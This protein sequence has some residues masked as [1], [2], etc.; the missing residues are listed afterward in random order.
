MDA[1]PN[2]HGFRW[3]FLPVRKTVSGGGVQKGRAPVDVPREGFTVDH[4]HSVLRHSAAA[5][6]AAEQV[7]I[8]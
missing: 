2:P 6:A 3:Q 4:D 8:I 1:N 7:C 5:A